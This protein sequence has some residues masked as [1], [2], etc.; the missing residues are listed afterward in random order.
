ME[1]KDKLTL[2]GLWEKLVE[3]P[4]CVIS[5]I[6]KLSILACA[7]LCQTAIRRTR[8]PYF[9]LSNGYGN[10]LDY[11]KLWKPLSCLQW[12]FSLTLFSPLCWRTLSRVNGIQF[13]KFHNFINS[14]FWEQ[15][16]V[17]LHTFMLILCLNQ[18]KWKL[19][20]P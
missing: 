10:I 9:K 12:L 5:F 14:I 7:S 4:F 6:C 15:T 1:E 8:G 2:I 16:I 3:Q 17:Q 11:L 13:W 19:G 20:F 18:D